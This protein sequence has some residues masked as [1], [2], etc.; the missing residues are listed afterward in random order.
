M[1]LLF[2]ALGGAIIGLAVRYLLPH[3]SEHGVVLIPAIG[4]AVASV[5]WVILTWAGMPYDGGWIWWIT[6]IASALVSLAAAF[7]IGRRRSESDQKMLSR[8]MKAGVPA[9]R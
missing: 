8:L 4:T 5:L 9:T 1:E 6:L 2:V 7:L 3:R